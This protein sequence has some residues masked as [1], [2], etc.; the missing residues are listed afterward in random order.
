MATVA[1]LLL[2]VQNVSLLAVWTIITMPVSGETQKRHVNVLTGIRNHAVGFSFL[3]RPGEAID[4][5][6]LIRFN[7]APQWG[8]FSALDSRKLPVQLEYIPP[9]APS[10]AIAAVVESIAV[11]T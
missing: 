3:Q 1:D 11:P 4:K 7:I 5:L 10:P 6:W 8:G 9:F 2:A